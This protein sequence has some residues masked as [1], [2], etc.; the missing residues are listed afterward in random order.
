MAH[1]GQIGRRTFVG[2]LGALAALGP[3]A[4]LAQQ[5]GRRKLGFLTQ[6]NPDTKYALT[7]LT[8]ALRELGYGDLQVE[9]RSGN[10]P[11]EL[12][13]KAARARVAQGRRLFAFQTP[14]AVAAKQAMSDIPVV[15]LAA[16]PSQAASSKASRDPAAI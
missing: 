13:A 14:A 2:L 9:V 6:E 16:D 7:D 10:G 12:L 11:A 15:F 4:A 8:D 1:P 3:R 5:K